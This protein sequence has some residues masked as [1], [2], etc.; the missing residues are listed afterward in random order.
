MFMYV[1]THMCITYINI[2]YINKYHIHNIINLSIVNSLN[3]YLPFPSTDSCIFK[4]FR[5]NFSS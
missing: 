3:D 1:Y 2:Y 5:A 4:A